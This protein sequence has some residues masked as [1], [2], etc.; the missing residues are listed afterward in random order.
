[1]YRCLYSIYLINQNFQYVFN[2]PKEETHDSCENWEE[3][4]ENFNPANNTYEPKAVDLETTKQIIDIHSSLEIIDPFNAELKAALLEE[5]QFYHYIEHLD[6]GNSICELV[7]KVV[8]IKKG[9][10]FSIK[11]NHFEIIKQIGKG[12]FGTIYW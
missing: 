10:K 9:E 12:S 7:N 5:V 3:I 2:K 1:M 8:P 6:D 4:D 11:D